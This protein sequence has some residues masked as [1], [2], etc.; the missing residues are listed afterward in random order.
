MGRG[1]TV[2]RW[3][4]APA[5]GMRKSNVGISPFVPRELA[6]RKRH[7][8]YRMTVHVLVNVETTSLFYCY[9]IIITYVNLQSQKSVYA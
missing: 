4:E 9:K 8:A 5:V 1:P 3:Q 7:R 6:S 2:P